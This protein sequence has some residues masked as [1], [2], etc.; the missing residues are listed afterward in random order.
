MNVLAAI[1]E[2]MALVD[3]RR[4]R[5]FKMDV[6][7]YTHPA[8]GY[9]HIVQ[10]YRTILNNGMS[11]GKLNRWLGW[12]QCSVCS[13][14]IATLDEMKAINEMHSREEPKHHWVVMLN[15]FPDGVFTTRELAD[16]YIVRQRELCK[17][18]RPR[19]WHVHKFVQNKGAHE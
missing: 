13:W 15:D 14:G 19:Q 5:V 16:Y 10:M 6:E 7:N 12:I 4:A 1:K 11:E 17:D 18:N 9:D 2:T 3:N 8:T